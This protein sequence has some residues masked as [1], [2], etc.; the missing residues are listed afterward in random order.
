VLQPLNIHEQVILSKVWLYSKFVK[1]RRNA[2]GRTDNT[3]CRIQ[4]HAILFEDDSVVVA[5]GEMFQP[6]RL[7]TCIKI[8]FVGPRGRE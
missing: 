1:I 5:A 3:Q 8:H 2:G 7:N 4:V 6:E